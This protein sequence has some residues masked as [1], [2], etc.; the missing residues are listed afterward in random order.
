MGASPLK[1]RFASAVSS[2]IAFARTP[3]GW[4][5][6]AFVAMNLPGLGWGMP[7]SDGWD[8][9]GVAPRDF[10]AGLVETFTPGRYYQYPPVQLVILAVLSLP[11][12]LVALL[13]ARSLAPPDVVAEMIKVP[14]MTAIAL[15]ARSVSLL[16]AA[17]TLDALGKI[18]EEVRGRRAGLFTVAF[19]A[20]CAPFTYYARTSNLDVPYLFFATVAILALV[21]V[22]ARHDLTRLRRFVVLMVLA[23]GTKDQAYAL[24]LG[25]IPA[26]IILFF[27]L[28]PWAREHRRDIASRALKLFALAIGL[29]VIVDAVPFNPR[30]FIARVHFLV[31]SASQDYVHYTNDWLGRARV[32][33]DV[34]ANATRYYP[35]PFVALAIIG[36]AL[37]FRRIAPREKR[38]AAL[39]PLLVGISY[40]AFFNCVARRTDHRFIMPQAMM[41]AVY[42]G[43]GLDLLTQ[44]KDRVRRSLAW[45][46]TLGIGGI[47]LFACVSVTANLVL[48]PRYDAEAWLRAH[49]QPGD[50][51]ETHGLNVYLPRF[52]DDA[53]VI[54][55]GPD[56]VGK[57]NPMPGIT[58]VQD[59]FG[60]AEERAPRYIVVSEGWAWRYLLDPNVRLEPG[61]ILPPTQKKTGSELDGSTFFP[62]LLRNE[63]GFHHVHSSKWVSH[64]FPPL[65]IHASLSREVWIYE[66]N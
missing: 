41:L 34:G 5:L 7:A 51:I 59:S 27:A 66:R 2:A 30:G 37:A 55:V 6:I 47:A 25:A 21:R 31:G 9:D 63:R 46:I 4:I 12:T 14:Y 15:I 42:G 40:T 3:R 61:R 20:L 65:E 56:P 18:A 10:L 57:R 23:V 1:T 28:D 44:Q 60:N 53:R 8:N 43:M 19:G 13:H 32:V 62:A 49:T 48:D 22:I 58:E 45:A 64:I 39:V 16:M 33:Q 26:A 29:L 35:L 24:F 54:R 38:L 11:V 52:P 36:G 50:L 17:G